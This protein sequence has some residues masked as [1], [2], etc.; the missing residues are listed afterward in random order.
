MVKSCE[1]FRVEYVLFSGIII[2]I[3]TM[4]ARWLLCNCLCINNNSVI[5]I[6]TGSVNFDKKTKLSNK[7]NADYLLE[8]L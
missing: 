6:S 7:H 5:L 2:D 8:F 4:Q 3:F 1:F